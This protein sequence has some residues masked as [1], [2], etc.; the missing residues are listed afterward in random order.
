[1]MRS[2]NALLVILWLQLIWVSSQQKEVEQHPESLSVPEGAMAS[3]NCTYRDS[4]SQN[5]GW[6][7]QYPGKGLKLLVSTF[8]S[9]NKDE[10]RYTAHLNKASRYFSLHIRGS[11]PSDSATYLCAVSTQCSPDTCSL[12]QNLWGLLQGLRQSTDHRAEKFCC[13]MEIKSSSRNGFIDWGSVLM[14]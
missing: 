14:F 10:G 7:R 3:L 9:G 13:A 6:Y 4:A 2:L 11:Q 1:M 12:H 8:S 5:F